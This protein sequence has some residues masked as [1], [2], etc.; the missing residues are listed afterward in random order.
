MVLKNKN[1]NKNKN[2][3]NFIALSRGLDG[4]SASRRYSAPPFQA[5]MW[6]VFLCGN[7]FMAR[8]Y[9]FSR[10]LGNQHAKGRV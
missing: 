2:S 3:K 6:W 10:K 4:N 8:L 7:N 1:K 9:F 5:R